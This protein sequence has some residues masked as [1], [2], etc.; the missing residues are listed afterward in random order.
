MRRRMGMRWRRRGIIQRKGMYINTEYE[1]VPYAPDMMS[2]T[3]TQLAL[4]T[5]SRNKSEI[6]S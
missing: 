4:I 1:Q 2:K 5:L 3:I 6:I